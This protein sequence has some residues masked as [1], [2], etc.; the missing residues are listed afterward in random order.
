MK[1]TLSLLRAALSQDMNMFKY[2]T[3]ANSSKLKKIIFPVCLFIIVCLSL[4]VY[5]YMIAD[6]LSKVHLTYIMLTMFIFIV[7]I[8]A[9]MQGIYKSQGILFEARDNDLLFSLPISRSK[10]LFVRIFK[11]LL[12]QYIYNLMFLLPAFVIYIYFEKPGVI[13]YIV[14]LIMTLL[15]PM[16][17]IIASS[18][19]GYLVKL[20]SS[21]SRFKKI[22]QTV[23]TSII[24]LGVFFLSSNIENFIKDIA[25]KANSINDFLTRIYYPIGL[26]INLVNKFNFGDLIKLILINVIPF[27]LFIFIGSK[28]YFK[29]IVNS[30]SSS[31]RKSVG[32]NT[33]IKRGRTMALVRKE[34]NRYFS[35]PVY[36]FN[37]SFGLLLLVVLSIALCVNGNSAVTS[38]L[39]SYNLDSNVSTFLLYYGLILFS[40]SM[41]SITSSCISLEGATIN[42]TKSLP[43]SEKTIL[44]SKIL[45]PFVIELPF[46]LISELIFF[47]KF[48]PSLLYMFIIF[49]LSLLM[50]LFSGLVGLIVNLIYPKLNASNDTEVVKQSMSSMISVFIGIAVFIFSMLGIVYFNKYLDINLLMIIHLSILLVLV[51]CL[52]FVLMKFGVKAYK[53]LNV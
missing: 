3:K 39:S 25:V 53:K 8:L 44:R 10:I 52:Y 4:G 6:E 32:H 34:M 2:E 22:I 9:F 49:S 45:Y 19:L 47:I 13:F 1:K 7:S 35:S 21:K 11:L 37:T 26:Y 29:I 30:N 27:I 51:I 16:I 41:T 5:A 18:I 28:F 31:V 24:F 42:I 40:T 17:P 46:I 20:F 50:I 43:V 48:R 38:M 12:F 15:V 23:L 36:M 14:S 33:F